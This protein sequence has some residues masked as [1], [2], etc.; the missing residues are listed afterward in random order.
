MVFLAVLPSCRLAV[1][2]SCRLAVLPSRRLLLDFS[3]PR[4][5]DSS[6]H[7][8]QNLQHPI[9]VTR[10]ILSAQRV[11]HQYIEAE[12]ETVSE[13][14]GDLVRGAADDEVVD[15]LRAHCAV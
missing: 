1:L 10:V 8:P 5:L 14:G 13:L 12:V 7:S 2:P 4:P 6:L 9:L 11:D 3:T 15:Q